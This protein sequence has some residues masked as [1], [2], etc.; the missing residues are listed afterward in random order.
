MAQFRALAAF[1]QFGSGLDK[2]T[3][4]QLDRGMRLT[5]LL[6]QPQYQPMSVPDQVFS[7]YAGTRGYLDNVAVNR[8]REWQ[9]AFLQYAAAQRPNVAKELSKKFELSEDV[10]SILKSALDDFNEGWN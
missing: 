4:D 5:E 8:V 7:L 9:T 2:S 1:A 3:Q 6:K 10:E